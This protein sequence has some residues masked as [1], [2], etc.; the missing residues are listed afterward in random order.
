MEAASN[1]SLSPHNLAEQCF[2]WTTIVGAEDL[3][4]EHTESLV[5]ESPSA[6]AFMDEFA[7]SRG[8]D[9]LFDDEIVPIE[10]PPP[11]QEITQQFEETSLQNTAPPSPAHHQPLQP[12]Q[13]PRGRGRERGFPRGAIRGGAPRQQAAYSE[14]ARNSS[15]GES[16]WASKPATP[17]APKQQAPP[18][19]SI[20]AEQDQTPIAP[21]ASS[22]D[23]TPAAPSAETT[24]TTT[25]E[26]QTTTATSPSVSEPPTDAP[27]GPS[28]KPRPPA[29]R[30]DRTATG[31][32]AKPKLTTAELDAKLAAARQRSSDLAAAHARA[33]ADA[34]EFA[35]RERVAGE[36]RRKEEGES[37]RLGLEREKNRVRKLGVKEGREW[38]RGKEE[39][40]GVGGRGDMPRMAGRGEEV[41][42]REYEW[43]DSRGRGRGRGGSRWASV[44]GEVG[45]AVD[46]VHLQEMG[47]EVVAQ[48]NLSPA[49]TG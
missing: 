33:Q 34:D 22:Q 18:P 17:R 9:D 26:P 29:V 8:D 41:D 32:F 35:E 30:G 39:G 47:L 5:R 36:R 24:T 2:A 14:A 16:K 12:Q 19:S 27:T 10:Q 44:M 23:A 21:T 49:S 3:F 4:H 7:Q 6:K 48:G 45:V 15:L 43:D 46:V 11:V 1:S 25:A 40:I 13:G 37:R 31:G 20:P 28:T 38:D 42:L